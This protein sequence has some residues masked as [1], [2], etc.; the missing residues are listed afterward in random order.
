VLLIG[1]AVLLPTQVYPRLAVLPDGPG[2]TQVQVARGGIALV[3]DPS[4]P[5]GAREVRD[6]GIKI[7]TTVIAA[8]GTGSEDSVFWQLGTRVTVAGHGMLNARLE[9]V[10]L[11]RRTARPTNCCGDRLVTDLTQPQGVPLQHEGFVTFPFDL[12][13]HSYPIW[14]VQ[15]KRARPA[16]YVGEEQRE[17][18][19]TYVYRADTPFTKVG[20]Q[21]LPGRLFGLAAASVQAD[22]EYAD[23]RTF[24]AEPATGAVVGLREVLNQRYR[25]GERTVTAI[26]ANLDGLPLPAGVLDDTR[27]GARWLPWLREGASYLLAPIGVLLLLGWGLTLRRP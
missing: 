12:Q 14:D 18:M 8:P 6:V 4:A 27:Q 21:A 25:Y 20:T 2:T 15:L 11:D 7:T 10:S 26:S 16:A 5:A 13:K 24:W 22:A 1:L 9:T 23:Q 17:G 19:R 3:P